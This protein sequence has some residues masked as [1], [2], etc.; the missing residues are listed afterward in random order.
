MRPTW[1]L[2]GKPMAAAHRL[3]FS[4]MKSGLPGTLQVTTKMRWQQGRSLLNEFIVLYH[5]CD[6]I[7][8]QWTFVTGLLFWLA[9]LYLR[10]SKVFISFFHLHILPIFGRV[11]NCNPLNIS[12]LIHI[13]LIC[14]LMYVKITTVKFRNC[15]NNI[16]SF[17]IYTTKLISQWDCPH[18]LHSGETFSLFLYKSVYSLDTLFSVVR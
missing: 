14:I 4:F 10:F 8:W 2:R 13:Y 11:H 3:W 7:Q 15:L 18:L 6:F 5:W 16:F 9:F 12:F 17:L 1:Y